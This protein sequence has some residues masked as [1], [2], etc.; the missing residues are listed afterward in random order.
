MATGSKFAVVVNTYAR[1]RPLVERGL[2]AALDQSPSPLQVLLIDQNPE[3][4]ELSGDI[5]SVPNFRRLRVSS[6]SLSVA[7]NSL[8][9]ADDV[10]W[11]IFCDDDGR[12][13]QGYTAALA[14]AISAHPRVEVVAGS[15]IREDDGGFYSP[16]QAVGGDMNK[17]RY[18]KLLM[19]SNFACRRETFERLGGFDESFGAG[20]FWGSGEDTDFA[21]RAYFAGISMLY[22]PELKVF[23]ERPYAGGFADNFIKAFRY[24]RGKGALVAKWLSG[25]KKVVVLYEALEMSAVPLAQALRCLF[26]RKP[27]ECVLYLAVLV[28]RYC[29]F[30]LFLGRLLRSRQ[31]FR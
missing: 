31:E 1:S 26:S 22:C 5:L 16:R 4:M 9:V 14:D 10:E 19:G 23:H 6:K 7:R 20:T 2:R 8:I 11:L 13:G 17:F 3:E 15:I 27:Y 28:S 24:G 29:G 25:E 18:T 12:L 21:W 30:F